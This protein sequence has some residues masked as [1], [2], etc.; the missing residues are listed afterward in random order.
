MKVKTLIKELQALKNQDACI[1][2][3]IDELFTAPIKKIV[4]DTNKNGNNSYTIIP[5]YQ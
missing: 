5:K 1:D 4:R 2:I 3:Y